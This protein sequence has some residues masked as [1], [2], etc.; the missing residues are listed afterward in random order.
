MR[1]GG[2]GG[3]RLCGIGKVDEDGWLDLGASWRV[4]HYGGQ[5]PLFVYEC[6][7]KL[8]IV[9]I[10]D[11]KPSGKKEMLLCKG[12]EDPK[13]NI[14]GGTLVPHFPLELE[15][16]EESLRFLDSLDD[17]WWERIFNGLDGGIVSLVVHQIDWYGRKRRTHGSNIVVGSVR[18]RVH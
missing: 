17:C 9:D 16:E 4:S 3:R 7:I 14:L 12:A 5:L 15:R 18:R 10:L 11:G 6:Y 13:S 2:G 8:H 1:W